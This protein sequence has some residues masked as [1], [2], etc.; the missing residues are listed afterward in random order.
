MS[1]NDTDYL[2]VYNWQ[3]LEKLAQDSK[4]Y[5]VVKRTQNRYNRCRSKSGSAIFDP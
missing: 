5:K 3:I 2:H 4:N 1:R